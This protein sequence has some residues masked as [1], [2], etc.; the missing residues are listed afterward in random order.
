MEEEKNNKFGGGSLLGVL[1]LGTRFV[2][3]SG[4]RVATGF[5]LILLCLCARLAAGSWIRGA[6]LKRR[7]LSFL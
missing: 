5:R 4:F 6:R 2:W 1:R 3:G 7:I